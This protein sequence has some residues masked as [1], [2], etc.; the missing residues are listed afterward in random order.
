[1]AWVGYCEYGCRES[2]NPATRLK[3][4]GWNNSKCSKCGGMHPR[5]QYDSEYAAKFCG[6]AVRNQGDETDSLCN[7][8]AVGIYSKVEPFCRLHFHMKCCGEA[9]E[10]IVELEKDLRSMREDIRQKKD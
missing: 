6:H 7:A 5:R 9:Q 2:H 10:K 4:N 1:M 8:K 3:V